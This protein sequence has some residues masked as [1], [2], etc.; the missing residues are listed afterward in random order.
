MTNLRKA[1]E[2]SGDKNLV[3]LA[4]KLTDAQLTRMKELVNTFGDSLR[5]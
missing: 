3:N 4:G 5:K 1:L 2:D